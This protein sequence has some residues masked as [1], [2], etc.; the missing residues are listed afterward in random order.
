MA[1]YAATKKA[2]EMMAHSYSSLYNLPC[3]GIRFF[4]VYGPYGR[5]DLSLFIFTKAILEDKPIQIFNH[6]NMSRDFTYVDDVVEGVIRIMLKPA[7]PS[8]NW[9]ND[10]SRSYAPFRIYNIGNNKPID[11]M[12]FIEII[13]DTIGKKAKKEFVGMQDG[14]VQRTYADVDDLETD[15]NFKPTTPIEEGIRKFVEWY[16]EYYKK[17]N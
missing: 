14:D 15:F 10:P 8:K 2:N 9:E 13:E 1:M 16:K 11:L 5:P 7:E 3:T 12:K 4:T 17:G 6:G